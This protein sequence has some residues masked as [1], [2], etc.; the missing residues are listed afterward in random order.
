MEKK[1]NRIIAS[2]NTFQ[3]DT[4]DNVR[5]TN[6]QTTITHRGDGPTKGEVG[7]SS[8]KDSKYTQADESQ[9]EPEGARGEDPLMPQHGRNGPAIDQA[10]HT[11]KIN[12]K[13]REERESKG[14]LCGTRQGEDLFE[15]QY[16]DD[17][18]TRNE[19]GQH[20]NK[21][22][23]NKK[24]D[25]SQSE[26]GKT[27]EGDDRLEGQHGKNGPTRDEVGQSENKIVRNN[28]SDKSQFEPEGTR[29][30]DRLEGQ[31]GRNG[32]AIDETAQSEKIN[33]KNRGKEERKGDQCGTRQEGDLFEGQ[34]GD[35]YQTRNETGQHENKNF[36]NNQVDKSQGGPEGRSQEDDLLKGQYGD[37]DS[38]RDEAGQSEN[39]NFKNKKVDKSQSEPGKTS[40]A[41]NR[42]EGQH[43]KN[44]P[45]RDEAG[46][47]EN[48]NF[49]NNKVDES[50]SEPGKTREGDDRLEGQHGRNGLAIDGAGQSEK[51]N[52][53]NREKEESKGDLCGTRQE[54]D[55]FEGQYGDDYQTRNET[56]QHE[57]K[58]FKNKKVD[59]SQSEPGGTREGD[60][61]LEGQ[62]GKNGPTRDEVGQSENK[63]V[64]NN[65]S[66]KSQFEPEG[67]RGDDRLEGQHGKNGPTRDE[68]GQSE[69]KNFK[70]NKVDES[71]SEP[72]KTREGDDRLEGQ[73]GR[74][75]LAIDE[76]A[77]SEKI[78][79]KNRGKEERKGDQCGTRQEGDLFEGQYGDDYQTRNETGQHENKNFKNNQVDKSQGGPEGRSQEDDLLKGQYGDDDSTRDE[80]GQSENKNFKNKKVDKSQSEPGKT[81][82]ADNRLEG[83]HG[84]N[85][86]TRDEAGQ[87]ENK[88]FKNN[89][90]DES[91]SEPGKTREGDDRLEGQHGRNGLAI[92][93]AGQSEKINT[94]NREKEESKGDLC[95]TRQEGD[96]FEGQYGDDYQTRNETGQHE[97]KNFKNKKVDESQ[98]EPG[99]TREGDDRLEGQ[100][101]K[102]GPTR[103]EVGQSENKIVKN[104]LS[105]KSQFEPEGTRGD[106]RLEGQHGRNG[107]AIDETAQ[108][109]KINTKNRGKEERKGDQ[110]GTRQEGDLFEGQYGYDYQTRNETGQHENKNF[111]NNQVD[112]S[113]GGPE[114]RSQRDDLLKG[115]YGDDDSTR[116][117]AGQSENKNFKNN[118]VDKS[119]SEP[120]K[121][122]QEDD[123]L[124]GQ[125]GKNGPTRDEA[126]QSENK[127]VRNNLSDKSQ[128]ESEGTRRDDLLEGQHGRNRPARE[129]DEL[130]KRKNGGDSS[131]RDEAGKSGNSNTKYSSPEQIFT[132]VTP[133]LHIL[134][135]PK[136]KNTISFYLLIPEEVSVIGVCMKIGTDENVHLFQVPNE[137]KIWYCNI[138]FNKDPIKIPKNSKYKYKIFLESSTGD[139]T[140][141]SGLKTAA[142]ICTEKDVRNVE[143]PV[144]FDVFK[145]P[146]NRHR[147]EI[148]SNITG[149]DVKSLSTI[150]VQ[151]LEEYVQL[152]DETREEKD[153]DVVLKLFL[154]IMDKDKD[155]FT[156]LL[157]E[158]SKSKSILTQDLLLNVLQ[159]KDFKRGWHDIPDQKKKVLSTQLIRNSQGLF[160]EF[161][162]NSVGERILFCILGRIEVPNV[163]R[164][165]VNE[166]NI[167]KILDWYDVWIN[168]LK[169][170]EEN[171]DSEK[172]EPGKRICKELAE[173]IKN[174]NITT[175]FIKVLDKE[176]DKVSKLCA[177]VSDEQ[178]QFFVNKITELMSVLN[179]SS[180]K[181]HSLKSAIDYGKEIAT[182]KTIGTKNIDKALDDL[183][184]TWRTRE[185][186][187]LQDD[188]FW[189][190]Y[191]LLKPAQALQPLV[192]SQFFRVVARRELEKLT[193][194][195]DD[196]YALIT[197]LATKA[198][199]EFLNMWNEPK[200]LMVESMSKLLNNL[201]EN[202]LD[203]ELKLLEE[204]LGET[205]FQNVNMYTKECSK[206]PYT[207][208]RVKA[209][210]GIHQIFKLADSS[211]KMT[212]IVKF[213]TDL[214]KIAK[215]TLGS[216]HELMENTKQ[217]K[218]IFNLEDAGDCV[219]EELSRSSEL[220]NFIEEIADD[221]IRFL[222][223]AVEEHFD[224]FISESSVSDL[225]EVHGCLKPLI[226]K[227]KE[228]NLNFQGLLCM[229]KESS[230]G[231]KDIAGKIKQCSTNVNSLRGLYMSITNRGEMTKE[232]I[233]NCL[234]RGEYLVSQKD[235][236]CE[237]KMSYELQNR[238]K[239]VK[240]YSLS[241]LYDLRSRAHLIAISHTARSS[242][243]KECSEDSIKST[244]ASDQ[245]KKHTRTHTDTHREI[246]T[247]EHIDFDDFIHQVNLLTEISTLL[248]RLNSSGYVKYR[249][250]FSKMMKSTI[251]LEGNRD[252]LK[253]ELENWEEELEHARGNF[254][255][256]N[257]YHSD[258]ILTLY[259][260][261]KNGSKDNYPDVLSLLKF[262]DRTMTTQ[263]LKKHQEGQELPHSDLNKNP[264][265][266]LLSTV[267]KGLEKFF[268]NS[269]HVI[270]K[271]PEFH[272]PKFEVTP[273][274][275]FVAVLEA[276][277]LKTAKV[278]DDESTSK[279]F[280]ESY[281]TVFC[282]SETTWNEIHLLIQRC[283]ALSKYPNHKIIFCITNVE[284]L[285]NELQVRLVREIKEKQKCFQG[286]EGS[287]NKNAYFKLVL[288][289]R[290]G[291]KHHIVE[292]FAQYT[293]HFASMTDLVASLTTEDTKNQKHGKLEATVRKGEIFVASLKPNSPLTPNVIL[294]LYENTSK[295]FPEPS[296]IVFCRSET[297]WEEIQLLLKRCF[298]HPKDP[299]HEC[300]FCIACVE[301][302]PNEL[303]FK[304]VNEIKMSVNSPDY[305]LALIC[306][307]GD[308]H[309]IVEQFAQYTHHITGMSDYT[310]GQRL[311]AGW[312]NV[313]MVTSTLPGL[314]KTE[315]I[316]HEAL[317]KSMNVVTFSITGPFDLSKLIQR[318]KKLKVKKYHCLHL[319]IGELSD[320]LSLDTFL[321]QLIV[322][323][324][325][326]A[327]NQFYHLPTTH[328][329]IEIANTMKDKLRESMM[330][331]KYFNRIHLEW[332]HYKDYL[333][334]DAITSN[335]QIVCQY[336]EIFD[337]GCID[338]KDVLF[339]ESKTPEPL[340]ACRCQK[341]LAKHFS[342]KD[343]TTFTTLQTFLQVLAKQLLKFSRSAFFKVANLK[344]M[345]GDEQSIRN[346]LFKALFDVSKEFASRAIT[347]CSS[348][349]IKNNA[350]NQPASVS[351]SAKNMVQRVQGMTKW[352]DNNHLVVVFHGLY[353]QAITAFY[354][355][356][357]A[358]PLS[359]EKL[360]KSQDVTGKELDDFKEFTQ[361]QLQKKLEMIALAKPVRGERKLFPGYALT[362]D[363]ILKMILI[364]L[365]VRASVPVIIMGET[366]CGK[367]SLVQYLANTCGV[368]CCTFHLHAGRSE[369]EIIKFIEE[370]ES[371]AKNINEQVW[372]FLD[373]IN[374]CDHL[375]LIN[376]IMC[377]RTL[378]GY[379]LPK[380]LV[381][382]AA[383]NPYVLRSEEQIKTGGLEV[384]NI[385]DEYSGLV[386]R[387][388][389]LPE[390][391]ID[392]V[393]DYGSLSPT[394]ERDYIKRMVRCKPEEDQRMLVNLLFESQQFIRKAENNNFCVSLRD[395]HRCIHLIGW[396]EEKIKEREKVDATPP[397]KE[398]PKNIHKCYHLSEGYDVKLNS[399]VL[400]L[401]HCYLSRMPTAKLRKN[402]REQM[403]KLLTSNGKTMST[404][405]NS[406]I[407]EAIVRMEEDD[408]LNRMELPAGTARNAA[409]RENV[410]VMLVCILNRI[411]IFV[412]GKPG[413]S[414]SLSIQLI[415]SNLRGRDS[416]DPWFKKLPQLYVVSYQG[417][418]SST[419]E[420]IMKV[421]EKA[422]KYKEYNKDGNILPVV[423]LDEVG[424][425][426]NSK[427]NPL[428]VLHS[429]LEP[430]EG[431]LPEI[432]VVG[433]SNWSLDAAKM[434]RAIHLS[435]PEPT[436][437]DLYETGYSLHYSVNGDSSHCLAKGEIKCLADA[438]FE[439]QT[440]Q[441]YSNFHGLRD[442]YSLV[443]TVCSKIEEVN[444]SLQR[445]FGGIPDEVTNIQ[446]IFL[447]KLDNT[448]SC[449]IIPVIQLIQANLEDPHA[450]HLM[451]ITSGDSAIGILEQSCVNSKKEIIKIY[452]SRF[453]EDQSEEYNY[454]ILSRIILCME[455]NCI[456]ILRDLERI[457][458][459]LYDM[460]NQN[461]AV[462]KSRKHCRVAL[463]A[464]SNSMCQVDDGF[465]CIV[466]VDQH[467]VDYSDPPFLNR[468][469]KQLLRFSD[470]L[471]E[472][473][474]GVIKELRDWVK[475]M[476]TIQALE[477][478]FKETDLFIGFHE[479]TLPSLVLSHGKEKDDVLQKCK[480]D[481]MWI[482]SPDGVLRMKK[483]TILKN[484]S[485]EVQNLHDEY[486]KKPI[487][488]GFRA[489]MEHVTSQ[490]KSSFFATDEMGSKTV[491]MTFANI[492]TNIL[493]SLG[494]NCQTERLSAYKSEKQLTEMINKYWNAPDKELLVLQC[495]PGFD[496]T[497]LLHARF[498]IE[499]ERNAYK[500][501]LT[502]KKAQTNK[503]VCIVVHVQ[504]GETPDVSWQ[505]SFLSGW[506]L[507]FLDVLDAPPI[508]LNEILGK[509][510]KD[511]LTSNWPISE[512]VPNHLLWCFTCLKY[513][514]KQRPVDTVLHIAN[515]LFR[516][517]AVSKN[518]EEL[519]LQSV[520]LKA[521][522][523]VNCSNWQVR[524]ACDRQSLVNSSTLYY[525]LKQFVS[526]LVRDPLCKIVY[527]LEKEN[528]WPPH[529][530]QDTD[531]TLKPKMEEIWCNLIQKTFKIS[532]IPEYLVEN[533]SLHL[534]LP[535]S[536]LVSRKVDEVKELFL[537]DHAKLL[538]NDEAEETARQQKVKRFAVIIKNSVPELSSYTRD[539]YDL[540]MKDI[541]DIMTADF[542]KTLSRPQRLSL[543]QAVFLSEIKP[544]LPPDDMV[545]FCTLLHTFVW[546]HRERIGD[547]LRMIDLCRPF[548]GL[549]VL[550]SLTKGSPFSSSKKV[551][552]VKSLPHIHD[553]EESV[554]TEREHPG[555]SETF[556]DILVTRY[557]EE[558]LPSP[559]TV[560]QNGGVEAWRRN[561]NLLLSLAL[562]ISEYPSAVHYLRLCVN[563]SSIITPLNLPS[564]HNLHKIGLDLKPEYLENKKSFEEINKNLIKPLEKERS[565]QKHDLQKF[566]ALFYGC[567]IDTN[568]DASAVSPIIKNVLSLDRAEFTMMMSSVVLPLLM[569]EEI[570]SPG[571]FIDL[572]STSR[573]I[574]S[575]PCL[576][577][578]D[579]A[580]KERFE[581]GLIHHDS[582]PAVM[583]CDLIQCLL[584]FD[585]LKCKDRNDN[586]TFKFRDVNGSDC[587]VLTVVK[588]AIGLI[589][590]NSKDKCGL[591]VLSAVAFLREF[592]I[593]L[594]KFIAKNPGVVKKDSPYACVLTE[595]NSLLKY[596]KTS[597]QVFLIKQLHKNLNLFDLQNLFEKDNILSTEEK[598]LPHDM[599][600][601][602]MQDI[603]VFTSVLKYSEYEDAK[604]SFLKLMSE[605]DE[606][607]IK[608]F[609][610]KCNGSPKHAFVLLGMLI[611]MVY[612]KR[613]KR[614]LT[615]KEEK[616][617]EWFVVN[618]EPFPTLFRELL[619]K[620]IGQPDFNC[621]KLQLTPESSVSEIE[622]VLL[623]LHVACIVA[624]SFPGEKSPMYRYFTNPQ[625][626][627]Q[628]CVLAHGKDEIRSVFEHQLFI[629]ESVHVTCS[630][631]LRLAFKDTIKEIA[632]PRCH[633]ALKHESKRITCYDN[634]SSESDL[635]TKHMTPAVYRA[636][637]LIVYSS[638]YAGIEVGTSTEES[639]SSV[640]NMLHGSEGK[641]KSKSAEDFCFET[642]E[643]DMQ[644]LMK[645]LSNKKDVVIKTM[646]VVLERSSDLIRSKNLLGS[647]DCSTPE[648]RR[649]WEG[650]FAKRTKEVFLNSS[651]MSMEIKNMM[652]LQQTEDSQTKVTMYARI[653]ELDKYP[654]HRE[655]QNQ[656]LK[657]LFRVTKQPSF[658]DFRS[659]F[660][661]SPKDVQSKH[662]FLALFFAK[663]NQLTMVGNLHHLLK[664]SRL[665][666]SALTH[667][668]SRK[669]AE[670][671][672][673]NDFITGHLLEI[674]RS[675]QEKSSFKMLFEKF[676]K[677]WNEVCSLIEQGVNEVVM[678]GLMETD[679]IAYCLTEGEYSIHLEKA[680]K[681]LV[682]HQNSILDATISLSSRRHP[683]L[684]FLEKKNCSGVAIA[685]IQE[686]KEEE[687]ISF[688]WSDDL[689]KYTPRNLEYGKGHEIAYDFERI[690]M[691]L[692]KKIAFGK[693][694]LAGTLNKFIFAKE[695]FHICGPLLTEFRS[696]IKQSE[697]LPEDVG[698]E[699]VKLKEQRI[700][701]AQD[702]LQHIEVLIFLL[703]RKFKD[704]NVDMT[705]KHFTENCPTEISFPVKLFPQ[706]GSLIKIEHV[707]ALYEALE[708][709]LA[710]GAIEGLDRKF[711]KKLTDDMKK[712]VTAMTNRTTGGAQLIPRKF[713]KVLRRFVFRYLS[714]EKYWPEQSTPLQC[715]LQEP[716]LWSSLRPPNMDDIPKEITLEY[717]YSI[718]KYLE[719]EEKK[720]ERKTIISTSG[721]VSNIGQRR[722]LRKA[723]FIK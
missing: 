276:G 526:R 330:I 628:P 531:D 707:A 343:D 205:L 229:L 122:S 213:Q 305:K 573:D 265:A 581:Q 434:N 248:L 165:E 345:V 416:Q 696:L 697:T 436:K 530:S 366:G 34:Y 243:S 595:I 93:G 461:Y 119:Q 62:H 61:R 687:I 709:V 293:Q 588:S 630:C 553:G 22:F 124:E 57:N 96:L 327:E 631:S 370:V 193:T 400:A 10:G 244:E 209:I 527:F 303:Q 239:D 367:T 105:D 460:L 309:H 134:E 253:D 717:I 360:L 589:S 211:G 186:K 475:G 414:K 537:E 116:D 495:K 516:S 300:L 206:Y 714:S 333:V 557:C 657:R 564:L 257:Y 141:Q 279:I 129:R 618:T 238:S 540:Y 474:K 425:A 385:I 123:R 462:V 373:E 428:K 31:H 698:K 654:E 410:F 113:Q 579:V 648:M 147:E 14:D 562:I 476:S 284:L 6:N 250:P 47:S 721:Q 658:E 678:P 669:D 720:K 297:K 29:G 493:K 270:R 559:E 662:S 533:T 320:P 252:N 277:S 693:C 140:T 587:E 703:K 695:L 86:P 394:D 50:Q 525:A 174:G 441:I 72:G 447:N 221:D 521:L 219:V 386:Y 454:R 4:D 636:L 459:S 614:K 216:L 142:S 223:D 719:E 723:T 95:G 52:T 156:E 377:H 661:H 625:K 706:T 356:K 168:L 609:L 36:K 449:D 1:D 38:T 28:L 232:V 673:I 294:A 591:K 548:I 705:L 376:D 184:K 592:I 380:N 491:V 463:G 455:R 112:K 597:L 486:F 635:C 514:G 629:Q 487:H 5:E 16:G 506:R 64:K 478:N 151:E 234:N 632:C 192:N 702:L 620:I 551:I 109:E 670:S 155:E 550:E 60:D 647:N 364:I 136:T 580:F 675:P 296:Q 663:F 451:L 115:Q 323:G 412:V 349:G 256:L 89:K 437:D 33:T 196:F 144:Q 596:S 638:Y 694:Y 13:N 634:S 137:K 524:V 511:L 605:E 539:C 73:H 350:Q 690:E 667:R 201:N 443:K 316:K 468:F 23:K 381:F 523:D 107:L 46:Q 91:Q 336:L 97:N 586:G 291:D 354:R 691:W 30:D 282:S 442:Y 190:T 409:L 483:C 19:T 363:N 680:I 65:L 304:M 334:T 272:K 448:T 379:S 180:K 512:I 347:T 608:T 338:S 522:E 676:Q 496:G 235:G 306:R 204:N 444:V 71:Q 102:N 139:D 344:S 563:F 227:K 388:H 249:E 11:E 188:K 554:D 643:S 74:N 199:E 674:N 281:Q 149:L 226:K 403:I 716:S 150:D 275:I 331:S 260:F 254:H 230:I 75:G 684:G 713:L 262:V 389:P 520:D 402:Y 135:T 361:E 613:T 544:S 197:F 45:T 145:F 153:K 321:F 371:Y 69:N 473:Q 218:P 261:F 285:R 534:C 517:E 510:V 457:Y 41:D 195:F 9:F 421:F 617:V 138:I 43:G 610:S 681:M 362:P 126:G 110:C 556:A 593:K 212:E 660:L 56:G 271:I 118:Q 477:S 499:E 132:R 54:G 21:N 66:D 27:R 641:H 574:E 435:R 497:H 8:N 76:T 224:Q 650:E 599:M 351:K 576:Q 81:S 438:Y 273:G 500:R 393:W 2:K 35:D 408:I 255:F 704:I 450:R 100:H 566:L 545:E 378:L 406:D 432:A 488:Q 20:E 621:S 220:V 241:E 121:T 683:A 570:Q 210:I 187:E 665:V 17:Y 167:I 682:S 607:S 185:M 240:H 233:R 600:N 419:S 398:C 452:G 217:L 308:H 236:K 143:W 472:D 569:V 117:E 413:C 161:L 77:Q 245:G 612:L 84:K 341:L 567:C 67:T 269:Q 382:L 182:D 679:Y 148:L 131:T 125:H 178:E 83:Q 307:G 332:Q 358:V 715:H 315:Q 615:D 114:G 365:R 479:D 598:L 399:V 49:K 644:H 258:Q 164:A 287:K 78:N 319:D 604:D 622:T 651:E 176:K 359:V 422:Q 405:D 198:K 317:D 418:E 352:K 58:N 194:E 546:V 7:L 433:I 70:N 203:N 424:L 231:H 290:S 505:F 515:N 383:C 127:N 225:I 80:A 480:D 181:V 430:G 372:A 369:E 582:Y 712:T 560:K 594:A 558:M 15:G 337:Q 130:L 106:D 120:G 619:L 368:R 397:E 348:K 128:G 504:R 387:V 431:K 552:L 179:E 440:Q 561:A 264:A 469:E 329:Y 53:K 555:E 501:G 664:W 59:E 39:K 484:D 55:L 655:E 375:G 152:E 718:V 481:L 157:F 627:V 565:I 509:S 668:I 259:D 299:R 578:I 177:G 700:K 295:A 640:L 246:Q 342:S 94:K 280:R 671:K 532:D 99:G 374:T 88:N 446:K 541:F 103:D 686:V 645:I 465:R 310:F 242:E 601:P 423:L 40:Q 214:E 577:N 692:A 633:E 207:L 485:H 266:K 286:R 25:E 666:S 685:S 623:V 489:F 311:K 3:P 251:E 346:I 37:D 392:Y 498:I 133:P 340:K 268:R 653:L 353:S 585:L 104:N 278:S 426:E 535:F 191:S 18:Q 568:V 656:Q 583:I 24:V 146:D 215:M 710:D 396:F 87:S 48:K 542:S 456:L 171:G 420:G 390:A 228:G 572:I 384:K 154:A 646:H 324:M 339:S 415:R 200:T 494:D 575:C 170:N 458:G 518:I 411:P 92:D 108:S 267:G 464:Y 302:L 606:S 547:L 611:N 159:S 624:T 536:Q 616:S 470:V 404:K 513:T 590:Q 708:D 288:I 529:L 32:L 571:I 543:A 26:P 158:L 490:Q 63:I 289:C 247:S 169:T 208:E 357:S 111:K 508:P 659:A 325:V 507:V 391:M 492:H 313:K 166:E 689:L 318:L 202:E 407:F 652:K 467:K 314:G 90:V 427:Y 688:Q 471:T 322:T 602:D 699:L 439:Y 42:L 466:L 519:I 429:L 326:S 637:H 101:G 503:H 189:E 85:G 722:Q 453:E 173:R 237:I 98:S 482:A 355:D 283:F 528:A 301:L 395:V 538:E 701:D 445:N 82:Q 401:A 160:R 162:G 163:E 51:I 584:K 312:P 549:N 639:V 274:E 603:A 298:K 183:K 44:G 79:T 175:D 672:S 328:V 649:E 222:I 335:A 417:S 172:Y 12:T 626:F 677:A 502:K 292:Q 68:A 711:R 642:I 263:Q